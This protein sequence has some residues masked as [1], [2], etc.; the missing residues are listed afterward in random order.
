MEKENTTKDKPAQA[1]KPEAVP[2]VNTTPPSTK[3]SKK[4]WLILVI[5]L[6]VF[7]MLFGRGVLFLIIGADVVDP[8]LPVP[9]DIVPVTDV[10][11]TNQ[12]TN[13]AVKTN[14]NKNSKPVA[15]PAP[16]NSRK[17]AVE[18]LIAVGMKG[19]DGKGP[20]KVLSKWIKPDVVYKMLGSPNAESD[21]CVNNIINEMN[22]LVDPVTFSR[23][24]ATSDFDITIRFLPQTELNELYSRLGTPAP[25]YLYG[26]MKYG[27]NHQGSEELTSGSIFVANDSPISDIVRCAVTRHEMTHTIGLLFNSSLHDYSIFGVAHEGRSDYIEIDKEVIRLLYNSGVPVGSSESQVRSFFG[28]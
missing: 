15:T 3:K 17:D 14:S 12:N 26:Y 27:T 5:I 21:K 18:Y 13:T 9:E 8:K 4:K 24:D 6:V 23:D 22:T 25:Q 2:V 19:N 7:F 11:N 20:D 1:L 28:I 16:V 10:G